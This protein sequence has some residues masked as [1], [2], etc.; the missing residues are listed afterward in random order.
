MNLSEMRTRVRRDLKDED[1]AAYRWS[2]SEIDRHIDHALRDLSGVAPLP[3]KATLT[4][5]A[6]SRDISIGALANLVAIEAVEYPSGLYPP[7]YVPYSLWGATLS[8]LTDSPPPGAEGVNIYY[9]KLHTLDA[10]TS[11][12]PA[13][14]EDLVAIGAEA[15]AAIEWA[16]FA[17][18]R[19]NVGGVGVAESYLAWGQERLAAF[20]ERL[21][22]QGKNAAIRLRHLYRPHEPGPSQS[23]DWGP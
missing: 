15:Y 20:Q 7:S 19:V 3:A 9:G 2:D 10:T 8:L 5:T 16:S 4:T 12:L 11:T 1:A 14:L 23:T 18:N 17:S 22:S 6:G 13:A 21:G